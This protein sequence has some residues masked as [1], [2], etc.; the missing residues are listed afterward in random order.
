MVF[1]LVQR[2]ISLKWRLYCF[3]YENICRS[4]FHEKKNSASMSFI[5]ANIPSLNF[6][7][8]SW[9]CKLRK[10]WIHHINSVI[11]SAFFLPNLLILPNLLPK[12]LFTIIGFRE[13]DQISQKF[14]KISTLNVIRS[15]NLR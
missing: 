4:D 1:Y 5:F 3:K 14:P 12:F 8:I 11:A 2:S 13:F 9:N 15:T 7:G 6:F 10:R